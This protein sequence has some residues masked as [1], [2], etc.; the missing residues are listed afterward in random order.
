MDQ[1]I[2]D[3]P[4]S[5][6]R[7][8]NAVGGVYEVH[9]M[10][11]THAENRIQEGDIVVC[12]EHT[13]DCHYTWALMVER[14]GNDWTRYFDVEKIYQAYSLNGDLLGPDLLEEEEMKSLVIAQYLPGRAALLV[15]RPSD[16]VRERRARP[17]P[18]CGKIGD[19]DGPRNDQSTESDDP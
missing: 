8:P 10:H 17:C 19:P 3:Q 7:N 9:S 2:V 5:R 11:P 14:N 16:E 1:E 12:L 6:Q 18:M 15:D 13:G 4:K